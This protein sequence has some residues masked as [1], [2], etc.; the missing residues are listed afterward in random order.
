MPGPAKNFQRASKL[1]RQPEAARIGVYPF[2]A[3]DIDFPR[4][5][6]K[7]AQFSTTNAPKPG[8][9]RSRRRNSMSAFPVKLGVEGLPDGAVMFAFLRPHRPH[10]PLPSFSTA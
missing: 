9:A 5:E 3:G 2:L 10:R 7:G 6:P 8:S 1:L 4:P